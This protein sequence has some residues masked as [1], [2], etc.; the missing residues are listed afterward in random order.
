MAPKARSDAMMGTD[1]NDVAWYYLDGRGARIFRPGELI[2]S[3]DRLGTYGGRDVIYRERDGTV[4][5]IQ[6]D[7]WRDQ[8]ILGVAV[9]AWRG[10]PA[11]TFGFA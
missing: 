7:V 9:P 8:V 3:G 10:E 11:P 1:V 5:S 6:Y 4:V 2:R